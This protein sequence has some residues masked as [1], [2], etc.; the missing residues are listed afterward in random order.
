MEEEEATATLPFSMIQIGPMNVGSQSRCV[1]SPSGWCQP[2]SCSCWA[3]V[4]G[5]HRVRGGPRGCGFLLLSSY[6]MF[7]LI[8][9]S[10]GKG[11][12]LKP[13]SFSFCVLKSVHFDMSEWHLRVDEIQHG[14]CSSVYP[15]NKLPRVVLAQ[16]AQTREQRVLPMSKA[17][18]EMNLLL[19][20]LT[21]Q[22]T[23]TEDREHPEP[24]L[25]T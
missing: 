21:D 14:W 3:F 6:V 8:L 16:T 20:L 11:H 10:L 5:V 2:Y 19:S 24:T 18:W 23:V 12:F 9:P 22:T 13:Y 7:P 4:C 15:E 17:S 1:L 25:G